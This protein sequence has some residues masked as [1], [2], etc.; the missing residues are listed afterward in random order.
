LAPSHAA[1]LAQALTAPD[2]PAMLDM[3]GNRVRIPQP[4]AAAPHTD[5]TAPPPPEEL[6]CGASPVQPAAVPLAEGA[7]E[8]PVWAGVSAAGPADWEGL[9]PL[10]TRPT[11]LALAC[12]DALMGDALSTS[13]VDAATTAA[14]DAP[15]RAAASRPARAVG[16]ARQSSAWQA[17]FYACDQYSL[18][19]YLR[20]LCLFFFLLYLN[21]VLWP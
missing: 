14:A 11:A 17:H 5:A 16:Q 12:A 4:C 19:A 3:F 10:A 20:L 2:V 21:F 13:Y 1:V 6:F 15:G 7:K 9:G 8:W 18:S